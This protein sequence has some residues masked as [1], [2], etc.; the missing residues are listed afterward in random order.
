MN[1]RDMA[2]RATGPREDQK[3][4]RQAYKYIPVCV[5]TRACNMGNS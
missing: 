3:T 4:V 1:A 5:G 2:E